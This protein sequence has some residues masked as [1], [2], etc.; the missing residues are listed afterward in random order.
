[1]RVKISPL[2]LAIVIV[3]VAIGLVCLGI[4]LYGLSIGQSFVGVLQTWFNVAKDTAP[5]VPAEETENVV[6]TIA[7]VLK[8]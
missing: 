7:S 6:N 5:N 1:M 2:A 4:Y 3:C 8:F